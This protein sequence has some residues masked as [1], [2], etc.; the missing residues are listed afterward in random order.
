MAW[1]A[2]FRPRKFKNVKFL[3]Y[4]AV[5]YPVYEEESLYVYLRCKF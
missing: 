4:A 2:I 1:G 3:K 5:I